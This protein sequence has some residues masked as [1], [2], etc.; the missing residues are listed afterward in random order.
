MLYASSAATS[1]TP[2][3]GGA[4]RQPSQRSAPRSAARPSSSLKRAIPASPSGYTPRSFLCW[5]WRNGLAISPRRRT[6]PWACSSKKKTCRGAFAWRVAGNARKTSDGQRGSRIRG[7]Q[8]RPAPD[9]ASVGPYAQEQGKRYLRIRQDMAGK[10]RAILSGASPAGW[11][12]SVSHAGRHAHVRRH[13]RLRARPLGASAYAP[14]G[15]QAR[16]ARGRGAAHAPGNRLPAAGGRRGPSGRAA[17][18]RKR[19]R[20]LPAGGGRQAHPPADRASETALRGR[21]RDGRERHGGGIATTVRARL[22]SW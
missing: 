13:W 14:S 5:A 10:S 7:S 21:T 8:R 6:I 11:S 17:L 16:G 12:R 15:T 4:S 9:G 1:V 19:R 22:L 2:G 3:G 20:T 18:C